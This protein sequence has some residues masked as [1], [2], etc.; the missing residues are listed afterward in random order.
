MKRRPGVSVGRSAYII[1][2]LCLQ[3]VGRSAKIQIFIGTSNGRLPLEAG[4]DRH[5]TLAK[6]VSDDLQFFRCSTPNNLFLEF[7]FAKLSGVD[8]VLPKRRGLGG[9]M[10]FESALA[11]VS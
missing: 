5:E 3:L 11:G 6:R 8:F 10:N 9:A 1:N 7:L 4:S 2:G